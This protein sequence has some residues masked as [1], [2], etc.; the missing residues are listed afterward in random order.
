MPT[1]SAMSPRER[2]ELVGNG[3]RGLAVE[4]RPDRLVAVRLAV[5]VPSQAQHA[6]VH[7]AAAADDRDVRGDGTVH[8]EAAA[9]GDLTLRVNVQRALQVKRAGRNFHRCTVAPAGSLGCG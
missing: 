2:A 5:P 1:D 6:D 4:I 3:R 7:L 9:R 8:Q